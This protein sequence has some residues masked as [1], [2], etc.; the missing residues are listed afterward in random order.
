MLLHH[1]N[2][3]NSLYVQ[4]KQQREFWLYS[5][6]DFKMLVGVIIFFSSN[7]RLNY[8]PAALWGFDTANSDISLLTCFKQFQ[9]TDIQSQTMKIT[10]RKKL[11]NGG[12]K[13]NNLT[14]QKKWGKNEKKIW[15]IWIQKSIRNFS[16][17]NVNCIVQPSIHPSIHSFSIPTKSNSGSRRGWS[18]SQLPPGEKQGTPQTSHQSIT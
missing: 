17:F 11:S 6:S 2:K 18:P 7:L 1:I 14:K 5:Y 16:L 10:E 4:T 13:T 12:K 15:M 9:F 8:I 3:A